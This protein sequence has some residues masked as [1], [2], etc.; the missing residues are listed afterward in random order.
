MISETYNC[1]FFLSGLIS[2]NVFVFI[3]IVSVSLFSFIY[4]KYYSDSGVGDVGFVL[5]L[6]G[7]SMNISERVLSGCVRDYFNFFNLFHFN[8]YDIMVTVGIM[9]VSLSVW[10]K[11]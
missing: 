8:L 3:S 10:K 6:V 9:L 1:N 11:K 2:S 5:V 4:L 7:G